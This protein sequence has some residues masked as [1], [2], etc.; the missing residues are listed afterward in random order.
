MGRR[1][2]LAFKREPGLGID[3]EKTTAFPL[4]STVQAELSLS[5]PTREDPMRPDPLIF[6]RHLVSLNLADHPSNRTSQILT[7]HL[8]P[9]GIRSLPSNHL[10]T[11]GSTLT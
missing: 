3:L 9:L 5:A 8:E 1:L 10:Q 6:R 11:V 7:F 2:A 4:A